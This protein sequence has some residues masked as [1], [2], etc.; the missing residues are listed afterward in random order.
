[1]S[2]GR[3]PRPTQPTTEPIKYGDVFPVSGD[4]ASEPIAPKDA[5]AV[6]AAEDTALGETQKGGPAAV[7]TSAATKNGRAGLFGHEQA[8]DG[9]AI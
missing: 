8:S 6:Q 1:M 2:Q 5:A 3:R 7:M 9:V 4:L